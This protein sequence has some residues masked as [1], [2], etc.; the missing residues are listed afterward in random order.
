MI[1]LGKHDFSCFKGK[2]GVFLKF[3]VPY[4]APLK[5]VNT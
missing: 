3:L 2:L 1:E 5:T 4:F